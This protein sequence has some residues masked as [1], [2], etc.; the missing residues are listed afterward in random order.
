MHDLAQSTW[1][2]QDNKIKPH[3]RYLSSDSIDASHSMKRTIAVG[4][5]EPVLSPVS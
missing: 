4:I 1:Y 3:D 5:R 2:S